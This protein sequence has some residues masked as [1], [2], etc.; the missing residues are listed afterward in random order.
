MKTAITLT[1]VT[2]YRLTRILFDYFE[3]HN[4][5]FRLDI[6]KSM[7]FGIGIGL[8]PGLEVIDAD[9]L[10]VADRRCT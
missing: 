1:T 10:T 4:W 5:N 3:V 9:R 6:L 2:K 8:M 7:H